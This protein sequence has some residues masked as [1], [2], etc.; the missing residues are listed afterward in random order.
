MMILK[1][2]IGITNLWNVNVDIGTKY[3]IKAV[4]IKNAETKKI[5][6]AL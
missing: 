5:K 3:I 6:R 1:L 2:K 4:L